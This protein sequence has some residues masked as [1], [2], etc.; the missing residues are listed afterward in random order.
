[1][2]KIYKEEGLRNPRDYENRLKE[3]V[4]Q[5]TTFVDVKLSGMI[6]KRYLFRRHE[7]ESGSVNMMGSIPLDNSHIQ[8]IRRAPTSVGQ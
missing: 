1:M 8:H 4:Q 2:F 5:E 6:A 7:V 3:L